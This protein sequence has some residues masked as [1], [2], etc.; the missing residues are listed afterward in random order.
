MKLLL[1]NFEV[2]INIFV[3]HHIKLR[4]TPQF[5]KYGEEILSVITLDMSLLNS[6]MVIQ[7]LLQELFS[8]LLKLHL[9]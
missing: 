5:L 6:L 2:T 4:I 8:L 1:N 9:M 7:M 3:L